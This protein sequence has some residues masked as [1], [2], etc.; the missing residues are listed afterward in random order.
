MYILNKDEKAVL[1]IIIKNAR[2]DFFRINK[3]IFV[4][5]SLDEKEVLLNES[6]ILGYE[7]DFE[8]K[9][10]IDELE[11][12][13]EDEKIYNIVGALTYNEKSVLYFYYV[14]EKT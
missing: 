1:K 8:Y 10:Q 2:N 9:A 14:E 3:Y 7:E 12:I 6:A 5:E 13:F 11:N 4:E